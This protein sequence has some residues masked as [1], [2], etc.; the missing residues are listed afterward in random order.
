VCPVGNDYHAHLAG[1]QKVIPEKTPEKVALAKQYKDDRATHERGDG[2]ELPG[3]SAWNRRWVGAEGYQGIV[4]R[5]M[6]AF[7]QLQKQRAET[8]PE[9]R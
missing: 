4:A 6:Q 8:E 5:Q 9:K 2:G 3:L 7:K 1:V